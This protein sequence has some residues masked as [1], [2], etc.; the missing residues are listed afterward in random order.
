MVLNTKLSVGER[1]IQFYIDEFSSKDQEPLEVAYL[2]QAQLFKAQSNF[3]EALSSI[4]KA[5]V[6]QPNFEQALEEKEI[7]LLLKP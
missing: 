7:I 1:Y 2:T 6:V 3:S 4:E 5:L